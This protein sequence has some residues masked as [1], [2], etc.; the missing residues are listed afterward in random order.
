MRKHKVPKILQ[1]YLDGLDALVDG[2]GF[3]RDH[4]MARRYVTGAVQ[5]FTIYNDALRH[6][7]YGKFDYDAMRA[8][9]R[10]ALGKE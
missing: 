1:T 4:E 5:S 2:R 10:A 8:I 9:A 3:N 6:V 7:A